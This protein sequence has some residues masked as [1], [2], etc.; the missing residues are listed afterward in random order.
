MVAVGAASA[1]DN[2]ADAKPVTKDTNDNT[3]AQVVTVTARRVSEPL[4]KVPVAVTAI[5]PDIIQ[6]AEIFDQFS[7]QAQ[8][9]SFQNYSRSPGNQN[10]TAV[11]RIRGVPGVAYYFADTPLP[12]Y[13]AT[14]Y[15]HL[16][17]VQGI[18]ILNG[19]Q[20]T[21]FG[22]ASNAGAL[23]FDPKTPGNKFSG[24]VQAELGD[25]RKKNFEAA[26]DLPI[27]PDRVMLRL[28]G[29]S[30]YRDG[31][32]A[33]VLSGHR[34]GR[35]DYDV[36][37]GTLVVKPT[38]SITNT[39]MFQVQRVRG[40]GMPPRTLNAFNFFPSNGLVPYWAAVN[41][42]T[43]AQFRSAVDVVLARQLKL[44]IDKFAGWST[45]CPAAGW[46]PATPSTVPGPDISNVVS[47]PCPPGESSERDYN[48]VNKTVFELGNGWSLKNNFGYNWRHA[49]PGTWEVDHS[50]LI[51]LEANAKSAGIDNIKNPKWS[52][53]VQLSGTLLDRVDL[54]SG[55]FLSR[56]T[57]KEN[58]RYGPIVTSLFDSVTS[59]DRTS[60]SWAVYGQGDIHLT[61]L[62]T[63]TL[64]ARYTSDST[65]QTLSDLDP[66]TFAVKSS[67]GGPGTPS[68]DAKWNAI[69]YTTSL[70][71]QLTPDTMIYA[72]HSKG[73]SAGGLQN[74]TGFEKYQ[75][76]ILKNYE[77]GAKTRF[78]VGDLR[79]Q[80]NA[81]AYY[82]DYSNV[83]VQTGVVQGSQ[84]LIGVFNAAKG[85]IQGA[86]LELNAALRP[87]LEVRAF[88]NHS[89]AKY[90]SYPGIDPATHQPIDLS[91]TP[92]P[93]N[94]P[95]KFGISP[96]Y[97]LPLDSARFGDVSINAN[98]SWWAQH[99]S[100]VSRP[101]ADPG[102]LA[103]GGAIC[104]LQRTAANG[105]GPLSADGGWS[106]I[107]CT[108][109]RENLNLSLI[110]DDVMAN[111][112]LQLGLRVSNVT[113][114]KQPTGSAGLWPAIGFNA[115][116]VPYPR[117]I[118]A[119]VKK[120]F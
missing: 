116:D 55:V 20:G 9:P 78:R 10:L 107:D 33:D 103:G 109:A 21:L 28:A 91:G 51:L 67:S 52:E 97:H 27:V 79:I 25:Y 43:E 36:F 47:Q 106:W 26:L 24:Y 114:N 46:R 35:E 1:Q 93:S 88:V 4:Q 92:F 89:D 18:Q 5:T 98:Y 37:R 73:H 115:M 45:G 42:M 22:Q 6:K 76:D 32:I 62:L 53:E 29:K 108:P 101:P 120:A 14:F 31:Y 119:W 48:V 34:L 71:Y 95:T 84:I 112:G 87:G 2:Q 96:T 3:D 104:K 81:A 38:S 8:V 13:Q 85:R 105:F 15:A 111:D 50:P 86:E 57:Y 77:V 56:E 16:F 12:L 83:Q 94:P 69:S 60:K 54:V 58:P 72:N 80:A 117:M 82:G 90:T 63:A 30:Y 17:D 41:G 44:G 113:N 99:W 75:P 118:S 23:I 102:N 19:P 39:T 11:N 61:D 65:V 68:G 70:R 74:L 59:V 110:W 100:S 66:A 49:S 64:G 7:L 40:F